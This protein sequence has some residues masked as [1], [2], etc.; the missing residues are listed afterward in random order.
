[1]SHELSPAPKSGVPP[2]A[3]S[4]GGPKRLAPSRDSVT[5]IRSDGSRPFLFPADPHGRFNLA[6]RL[7]ALGLV[8]FYLSLPWITVNGYPAVFLD[9]S[10][11]RFHLF[12]LTFAAQDIWLLFFV[13]TG[14]GFSLFF[15]T[16]LFGRVWCGWA[17]PQTV[18]L[19]HVYRRIERWIDGDAVKR[20]ALHG[21]PWSTGKIVR[22]IVKHALYVLVSAIITHLLLAYFVSLP[23]VWAMV[24]AAPGDQWGTFA[25]MFV[26][27]GVLYFNYAWF[28]EQLCIVI[29]PYGRIQ[30]TLIDEHSLVIGYDVK[31]GEP[32]GSIRARETGDGTQETG[33]RGQETRLLSPAQGDCTACNR[34]VQVCPTGIDIRQGLQME[35][36]G[37]TACIDACDDVMT[38]LGRPRGLI[39]YDSQSAFSGRRTRWIRPRTL[40]YFALLVLGASVAGWALSTVKPANFGVTRMTG[41]PY[42]VDATTVRN[43]FLVRIVNKHNTPERFVITLDGLPAGAHSVGFDSTV[44]V[45]SLGELV[46]PL[47]LQLA[48][49]RYA[50]PFHFTVRVRDEAGSFTLSREVEFLGPDAR[51]L[52]EEDTP[53]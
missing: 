11:L 3:E 51:L 37:C 33:G 21:A 31:R 2:A 12:G 35:C 17:C 49:E 44:E 15:I 34:C 30:S 5:T 16:A 40:L 1:M 42:I 47:V 38:R 43:Q 24:R 10:A 26:A 14:L 13:I 18:F 19:D 52:R 46:R 48:R 36:I 4:T 32:R 29:C 20:R 50:A 41:A 25:F 9:V 53:R 45:G 39:R 23:Q 6:R 28:R 7:S 8:V 22:R 27:T